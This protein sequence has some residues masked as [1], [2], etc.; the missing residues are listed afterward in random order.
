MLLMQRMESNPEDFAMNSTSQWHGVLDTLKK[1]VVDKNADAFIILEDF[2]AE[3]LWNKFK[4][5]GKK[6]FH[7]FVMQKILEGNKDER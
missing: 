5:A 2:E 3:M 1:R 6:S 4:A 7:T